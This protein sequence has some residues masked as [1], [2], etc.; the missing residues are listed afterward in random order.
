[1]YLSLLSQRC[2]FIVWAF[3]ITQCHVWSC[4]IRRRCVATFRKRD[5]ECFPLQDDTNDIRLNGPFAVDARKTSRIVRQVTKLE[6][7]CLLNASSSDY[8]DLTRG[9]ENPSAYK[10]TN[11]DEFRDDS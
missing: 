3:L 5:I 10:T 7:Y 11:S 2:H 6:P 4:L 1:M 9:T 8:Q